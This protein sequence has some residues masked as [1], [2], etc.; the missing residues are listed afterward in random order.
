MASVHL[1]SL[2]YAL[3]CYAL[4][5]VASELYFLAKS[6]HPKGHDDQMALVDPPEGYELNSPTTHGHLKHRPNHKP[7]HNYDHNLVYKP[8]SP[9]LS[10]HDPALRHQHFMHLSYC[11][12]T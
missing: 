3:L 7:A 12:T 2:C 10:S 5:V 6:H 1:M 9:G 4:Q 11:S 8:D